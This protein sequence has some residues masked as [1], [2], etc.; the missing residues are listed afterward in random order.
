MQGLTENPLDFLMQHPNRIA[1]LDPKKVLVAFMAAVQYH[2]VL[3]AY[4]DPV[5]EE[6]NEAALN[7][8][9]EVFHDALAEALNLSELKGSEDLFGPKLPG[10]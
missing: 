10:L 6:V 5:R 7:Y 4:N 2:D 1:Q 9:F 8:S 3:I